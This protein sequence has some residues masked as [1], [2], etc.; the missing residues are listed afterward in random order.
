[1]IADIA[2]HKPEPYFPVQP[3]PQF[4][5]TI[6]VNRTIKGLEAGKPILITTFYSNGLTLLSAL[7]KHLKK[8]MPSETFQEQRKFRAVYQ[9]LS[10]LIYIEVKAHALA[11]KKAPIMFS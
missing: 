11:V 8:T 2:I 5:R 3:L 1:M 10:N 6:N 4:N 7:Q 9:K